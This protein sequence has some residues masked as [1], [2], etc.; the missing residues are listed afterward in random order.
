MLS[1]TYQQECNRTC[2]WAELASMETISSWSP[3][4]KSQLGYMKIEGTLLL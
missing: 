3:D 1:T 2:D 4:F